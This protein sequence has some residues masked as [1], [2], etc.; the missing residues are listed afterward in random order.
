MI[1]YDSDYDDDGPE[2]VSTLMLVLLILAG[3][4]CLISI[5]IGIVYLLRKKPKQE[6]TKS[7]LISASE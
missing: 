6:L 1:S 3:A 7:D 5:L 4:I 2:E